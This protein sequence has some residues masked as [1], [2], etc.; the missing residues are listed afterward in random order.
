MFLFEIYVSKWF[1]TIGIYAAS[2]SSGIAS[3]VGAPR[4]LMAIA[5]DQIVPGL[6]IFGVASKS[7]EPYRGYFLSFIIAGLCNCIG[8]LN[9]VAPLITQFFMIA[10]LLLNFACLAMEMSK[11]PGWRPSFKYFNRYTSGLGALLC[12][13]FMFLLDYRYALL[14]VVVAVGLYLYIEWKGIN[15]NWGPAQESRQFYRIYKGL[16]NLARIQNNV[17]NWRPSFLILV[18]NPK[19]EPQLI[20]FSQTLRKSYSPLFFL[21]IDIQND[22]RINLKRFRELNNNGYLPYLGM[23]KKH[24][25]FYHCVFAD[26]LRTGASNAMQFTGIGTMRPNTLMLMFKRKWQKNS[27]DQLVEY[28]QILRDALLMRYGVMICCSF[29]TVNWNVKHYTPPAKELISEDHQDYQWMYA[30]QPGTTLKPIQSGITNDTSDM[31]S[32]DSDNG[33][34][35]IN[36]ESVVSG[37]SQ[38][39]LMDQTSEWAVGQGLKQYIDVYWLAQDGGFPILLPHILTR[40]TFWKNCLVRINVIVYVNELDSHGIDSYTQAQKLIKAMRFKY[41]T[42]RKLE[43][44]VCNIML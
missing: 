38:G 15:K 40:D 35:R 7:G 29:E 42:P 10:Y 28:I 39:L 21:R 4:I 36:T 13:V 5:Q 12:L 22:Y 2:L 27:N 1:V 3:L 26:S 9:A 33:D 24:K 23:K 11:T 8:Q 30:T 37:E 31:D 20:L 6:S 41:Q 25:G 44:P 34:N 43:I 18:K 14:A 17:K 32:D 19:T 16:L